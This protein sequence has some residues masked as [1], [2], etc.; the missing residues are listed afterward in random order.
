M[1]DD[2]IDFPLAGKAFSQRIREVDVFR[3]KQ[4]MLAL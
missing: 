1:K 4:Q 3:I 2:K